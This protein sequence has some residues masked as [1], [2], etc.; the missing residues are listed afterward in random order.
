MNTQDYKN[1]A[2][3][4][5]ICRYDCKFQAL[6]LL[7]KRTNIILFPTDRHKVRQIDTLDIFNKYVHTSFTP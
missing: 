4:F 3:E 2:R 7:A 5:K 6:P 1:A